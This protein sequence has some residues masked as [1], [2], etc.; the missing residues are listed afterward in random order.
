MGRA[1]LLS[2]IRESLLQC[3]T[4]RDLGLCIRHLH[5]SKASFDY[6]GNAFQADP[7]FIPWEGLCGPDKATLFSDSC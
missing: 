6:I 4:L 2:G 3:S 1:Q 7:G 5:N